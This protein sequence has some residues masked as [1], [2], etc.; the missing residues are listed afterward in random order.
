MRRG[1]SKEEHFRPKKQA[2]EVPEQNREAIF[3][4]EAASATGTQQGSTSIVKRG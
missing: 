1:R 3:T 2:W 4:P